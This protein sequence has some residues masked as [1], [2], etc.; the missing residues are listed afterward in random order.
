[1]IP[2]VDAGAPETRVNWIPLVESLEILRLARKQKAV[3]NSILGISWFWFFGTV[4]TAQLPNYA[5]LHLGGDE[6]LYIFA[7]ALFS[8]GTGLGSLLCERLSART[9]ELGLVPFGASA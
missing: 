2:K 7:L 5:P 4:L 8:I 6:T 1:M 3:R 9:V